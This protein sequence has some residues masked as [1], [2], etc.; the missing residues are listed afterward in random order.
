MRDFLSKSPF[1]ACAFVVTLVAGAPTIAA[2]TTG[3]WTNG[4]NRSCIDAC[5]LDLGSE[6]VISGHYK[7]SGGHYFVCRSRA[8]IALQYRGRAGFQHLEGSGNKCKIDGYGWTVA[9]DCLCL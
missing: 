8:P 4:Q 1:I 2:H 3:K 9:Y 5:K 6:P 7:N